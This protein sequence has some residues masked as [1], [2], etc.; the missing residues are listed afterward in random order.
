MKCELRDGEIARESAGGIDMELLLPFLS[1]LVYVVGVLLLKRASEMGVD[2]WRATRFCNWSISVMFV[3]VTLLG[4]S[5]TSWGLWWQ[6]A[7]TGF[8][9]VVGQVFSLLALKVGDVSVATPVLGV[10]ILLVGILATV[11]AGERLGASLWIAAA[12]SSAAIAL[13]HAGG[14]GAHRRVGTTILLS[15]LAAVIY[16]LFDVLVQK[17]SP[18]WGAG[19]F[20]PVMMGFVALFSFAVRAPNAVP[21]AQ[22][23][24]GGWLAGGAAFLGLQG[25][26]FV[27]A[28]AIYANV[29]VANV[30]YSSRGL[31]SV[32]AVWLVGHWF[33]NREQ[34]LGGRVIGWRMVGAALMLVAIVLV[35]MSR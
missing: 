7:L 27:T 34:H 18:N 10:K 22:P 29:T 16:A 13:L 9:F 23:G 33:G 31:W 24:A 4:G 17:W 6:P 32:V 3:P 14:G 2:V 28:V 30:L 15:G 12:L 35:V 19:R 1:G 20:L 5:I 8:L 21:K 26:M 25:L 11:L